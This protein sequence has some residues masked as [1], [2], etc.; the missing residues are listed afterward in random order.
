MNTRLLR[1]W[2]GLLRFAVSRSA[3]LALQCEGANGSQDQRGDA[4]RPASDR[5]GEQE[6]GATRIPG[7][8]QNKDHHAGQD[9]QRQ[10]REDGKAKDS[11]ENVLP[12]RV[13]FAHGIPRCALVRPGLGK[14]L[15]K[16]GG[17]AYLARSAQ[18]PPRSCNALGRRTARVGHDQRLDWRSGKQCVAEPHRWR[19]TSASEP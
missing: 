4:G 12:T 15:I 1:R 18:L 11:P 9:H 16:C 10:A 2:A 17:P 8:N 5:C 3:G 14:L 19:G 7:S 6:G 13:P